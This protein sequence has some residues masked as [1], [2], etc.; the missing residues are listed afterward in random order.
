MAQANLG[1][2]LEKIIKKLQMEATLESRPSRNIQYTQTNASNFLNQKKISIPNFLTIT[3]AVHFISI[4]ASPPPFLY[5][6]YSFIYYVLLALYHFNFIIF[7]FNRQC[8]VHIQCCF[9]HLSMSIIIFF[10]LFLIYYD[11]LLCT[12]MCVNKNNN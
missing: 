2:K 4:L 1:L 8:H 3:I 6:T 12:D 5:K 7:N 11:L 10:S 9:C